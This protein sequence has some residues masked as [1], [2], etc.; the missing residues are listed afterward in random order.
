MAGKATSLKVGDSVSVLTQ[1]R[2]EEYAKNMHGKS[3]VDWKTGKTY[4]T[5]LRKQRG[6]QVGLRLR[7]ERW[8]ARCM[9]QEGAHIRQEG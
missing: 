7:G 1:V 5:V 2:G 6:R 4:G 9:G 3:G 8:Q